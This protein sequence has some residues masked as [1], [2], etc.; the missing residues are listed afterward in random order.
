MNASRHAQPDPPLESN[1][2]IASSRGIHA[3]RAAASSHAAHTGASSMHAVT[4]R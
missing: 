4:K 3:P 1:T 2:A